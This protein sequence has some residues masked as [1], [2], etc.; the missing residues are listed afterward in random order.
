[1]TE[2]EILEKYP[3]IFRDKDLPMDQT[4]MCWGLE[5][6]DSWL[7]VIDDL[8]DCMSN[9]RYTGSMCKVFPQVVA[10]QVKEKFGSLRFYYHLEYPEDAEVTPVA[11]Y[12]HGQ[13]I[14]GMI[15][16]AECM[17]N[18]MEKTK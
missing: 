10:D 7:P 6:P 4:C 1:M 5:V 11:S 17:I 14:D 9:Y 16:M 13:Y 2:K 3:K 15:A 18:N 8:C 12:G